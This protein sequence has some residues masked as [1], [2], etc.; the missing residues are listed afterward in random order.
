MGETLSGNKKVLDI[1]VE[2]EL[3]KQKLKELEHQ[4]LSPEEISQAMKDLGMTRFVA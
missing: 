2:F 4:D 1:N 3:M